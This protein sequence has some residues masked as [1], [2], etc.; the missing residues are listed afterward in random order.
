MYV[1]VLRLEMIAHGRLGDV[2]QKMVCGL[3]LHK[4][5]V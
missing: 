3:T 5:D 1:Y 2:S 4:E